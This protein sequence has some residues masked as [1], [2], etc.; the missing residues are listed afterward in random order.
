MKRID[1]YGEILKAFI[2]L[3]TLSKNLRHEAM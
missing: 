3:M 1:F 2:L